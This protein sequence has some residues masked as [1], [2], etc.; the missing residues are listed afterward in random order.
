MR[1][2]VILLDEI[3]EG[4]QP[5]VI[6]RLA[7]A[8]LWEREKRGTAMLIVEQNVPFALK[9]VDRFVVLKQ[10]EIVDEGNAR[11]GEAV[12]QVFNH[13]RV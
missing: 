4:L 2:S 6:D 3:T 13:L 9:V 12:E 1:P 10:G 8:L 5:S 11:A 7:D